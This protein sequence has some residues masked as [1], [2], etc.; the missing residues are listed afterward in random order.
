MSSEI[1][2]GIIYDDRYLLHETGMH[3][4]KKERLNAIMS[5]L[6]KKGVLEKLERVEPRKASVEEIEY[7]HTRKYIEEVENYCAKGYNAL[8]LDTL[9]CTQSYD[10]ALLAAGGSIT[11]VDKVMKDELD[12][13]FAFVRPPGHHAEPSRGMGFC[14]FNNAAIA[15]YHAMKAYNLERILIYDWDVH[16]GNGTQ[17]MLYHDPRALYLSTHQSPAYPGTGSIEE[18][19]AGKGEGYTVNV[20]LSGGTS[21]KDLETILREILV[22]ICDEYKPQLVMVSAGHDAHENDPLAGMALTSQGYGMMAGI[23]K[24][25]ADEHCDGKI[26]LLLEGG[27]NLNALSESVFNVLNTLAGWDMEPE[28]KPGDDH[29]R[30]STWSRINTVKDKLKEYWPVLVK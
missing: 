27:Y 8:D 5:F 15:A 12:H 25:I 9:I 26:V 17:L 18:I 20:P 1:R 16:H 7:A 19:G 13:V 4:E 6:E 21:N 22:P 24:E 23:M 2:T 28:G 11:A 29:V 10:T 14:L 30:D 3:P